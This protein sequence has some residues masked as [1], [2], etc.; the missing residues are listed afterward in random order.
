MDF[1]FLF[2]QFLSSPNLASKEWIYRQY[3]HM[4]RTNTV[5]LPSADAAV[6]RI[7]GAN[8]A[9]GLTLDGN[10]RYCQQDPRRGAQIAVAESC[11]NLVC[12][13]AQPIAAT[14]C[15]NF[16]N[17]EKPEIM[18]QFSEVIDGMAEA[19]K[20]FETPITGGNVSFY[21]ETLGQGIYPSPV[22]G[23]VGL[24]QP[25][26]HLT[27]SWFV[28]EGDLIVLCGELAVHDVEYSRAVAQTLTDLSEAQIP[29]GDFYTQWVNLLPCPPLDLNNEVRVQKTC[30][31]AIQAGLI[32]SAHDCSEGGLAMAL[33]EMAFSHF[34]KPALGAQVEIVG[35]VPVENLLFGEYQSR[36]LVTLREEDLRALQAIA[37]KHSVS[38]LPLGKV[39]GSCLNIR[40][41]SS[42]SLNAEVP[43]LEEI[44]RNSLGR[45][46][47]NSL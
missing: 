1:G 35:D 36:I 3:D 8:K 47:Q 5:Q 23:M 11:R 19:C 9:L 29:C 4:V 27:G 6:I 17:P 28:K 24:I 38:I 26:S 12:V 22:I 21:N 15:L 18:W 44:W 32:L 16:G 20:V 33:A 43:V 2:R 34:G 37:R 30:L 25:L 42:F 31:E 39:A 40:I 13:G 10:G 14:N 7:K 41:G 45:F 46:F